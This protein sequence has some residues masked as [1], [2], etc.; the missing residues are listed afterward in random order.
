MTYCH[1][2][3]WFGT[4]LT[5]KRGHSMERAIAEFRSRTRDLIGS[6]KR[7]MIQQPVHLE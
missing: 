3:R 7:K 5:Y 4:V 6:A 2:V 1:L